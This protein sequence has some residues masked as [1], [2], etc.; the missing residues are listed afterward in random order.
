VLIPFGLSGKTAF[1]AERVLG[2]VISSGIK[3]LVLAVIIGIGSTVF[4]QFTQ[5]FGGQ[6]PTIDEAMAVDLAALSF[7]A[8][9]SSVLAAP[10]GSSPAA[11]SPDFLRRWCMATPTVD[12]E[13]Q[14]RLAAEEAARTS[15]VFFQT[16]AGRRTLERLASPRRRILPNPDCPASQARRWRRIA[17]SLSSTLP[18]TVAPDRVMPPASPYV[19][20]AG[21]AIPA[22]L[23]T[24]IRSDLPGQITAQ[25]TENVYDIPTGSLLLIPQ[26]TRVIGEYNNDVDSGQRRTGYRRRRL[27]AQCHPQRCPGSAHAGGKGVG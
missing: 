7:L 21:A 10:A 16:E 12:P 1:M 9:A 19:L 17:S 8:L 23:I 11:R 5:G 22:A 27:S 18:S 24:G 14:K 25:V 26:G 6:T 3:V 2:N 13:E 4:S 15:R 20:Q